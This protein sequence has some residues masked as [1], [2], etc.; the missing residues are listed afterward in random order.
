MDIKFIGGNKLTVSTPHQVDEDIEDFGETLKGDV[1][2]PATSQLFTITS[3]AKELDDE[4]KEF[5][6]SVTAKILCIMK[7][8]R[9]ELE[10]AVYF[11]FTKAQC[12]TEEGWGKLESP[13]LSERDKN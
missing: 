7:R 1:V 6:Y 11:L 10:T 12:P 2:N 13:E 4:K 5:Y 8:S 3:E 9:P